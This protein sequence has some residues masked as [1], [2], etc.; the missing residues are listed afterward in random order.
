MMNVSLA[1]A[2]TSF[3]DLFL[4]IRRS[5]NNKLA[6]LD[7]DDDD[8]ADDDNDDDVVDIIKLKNWISRN[9]FLTFDHVLCVF[10]QAK[11]F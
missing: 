7:D 8:Y 9:S 10:K 6:F 3:A 1:E 4:I 5:V 2:R 11:L